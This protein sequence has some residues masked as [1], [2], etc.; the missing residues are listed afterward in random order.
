[1]PGFA[2]LVLGGHD[3]SATPLAHR[4]QALAD[5]GMIPQ[6]Y[7]TAAL[8]GLEQADAEIRPGYHPATHTGT[9]AEAVLRLAGDITSF[10]DRHGLDRVV[11]VDVSSTEPIAQD[12]PEFH[13]AALLT[14]ALADS[15]EPLLPSSSIAALAAIESGSAYACFTPSA[16]LSLPALRALALT[17]ASPSPD[18]TA[19]PARP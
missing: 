3:I 17:A 18:R 16:G 10:R 1:M 12:R 9:Q 19:R 14:R 6:R 15:D 13:D 8:A 7:V 11:V 2:D 5:S 4:A